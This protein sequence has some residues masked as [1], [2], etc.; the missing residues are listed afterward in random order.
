MLG[1]WLYAYEIPDTALLPV[2]RRSDSPDEIFRQQKLKIVKRQRTL[3]L[4]QIEESRA[5]AARVKEKLTR[6]GIRG[7]AG[8]EGEGLSDGTATGEEDEETTLAKRR[9]VGV[10][11]LDQGSGV[12]DSVQLD[13][14]GMEQEKNVIEVGVEED[15]GVATGGAEAEAMVVGGAEGTTVA[16]G[17]AEGAAVAVGVAEGATVVVGGTEGTAVMD[18]RQLEDSDEHCNRHQSTSF[19]EAYVFAVHR[20]IVSLLTSQKKNHTISHIKKRGKEVGVR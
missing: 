20:R 6:E 16:V 8:P 5:K 15:V 3:S 13:E 7:G 4:K 9:K 12:Q 10:E 11:E 17:V 1:G 2:T 14:S 18:T 19:Q